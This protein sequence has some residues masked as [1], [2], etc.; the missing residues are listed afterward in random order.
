[1]PHRIICSLDVSRI[2][3][4]LVAILFGCLVSANIMAQ[5]QTAPRPLNA[6]VQSASVAVRTPPEMTQADVEAFLDGL[7]PAEIHRDD[8]AGVV[9][10]IVKDGKVLLEKGYGYADV[11]KRKPVSAT[12]TLFRP[13]STSKLFTW[14]AVMQLVEQGKLDLDRNVNDYL[15]FKIPDTFPQPITLRDIMTHRS[16]FEETVKDLF[17][18][19]AAHLTPLGTYVREHLP[20]RIFPPGSTPAYSNYATTLAGYI[21]ERVS[22]QPFNQ[23]ILEHILKPLGMNHSTPVQPLPPELQP[24]MSSGYILASSGAK[25]FEFVN[26]GPA[27]SMSV[28][29]DDMTHFMMAH[30]QDGRYG[31]AQILKPETVRLMH[32]AQFRPAPGMNAMALGF[33]EETRNGHRIIGHAGDTEY[34]HSDLHL[35]PDANVGFFISFN[36]MG[37]ADVSPRTVVF[38]KFLDRYFPYELPATRT[39]AQGASDVTAVSGSYM[40]SRRPGSNFLRALGM[41]GELHVY[42]NKD[43][44]I[45][46]GE[47][48]EVNGQPTHWEQILPLA[49]REVHG[50]DRLTFVHDHDGHLVLVTDFPFFVFQRVSWYQNKYFNYFLLFASLAVFALTVLLWPVGAVARRHYR[51]PLQ[52]TPRSSRLR[53]A[54]FTVSFINLAFSVG[55]IVLLTS[56]NNITL[57][58]DA[59]DPWL[60]LLQ[61]FGWLGVFGAIVVIYGV[62]RQWNER[63]WW[64]HRVHGVLMILACLSFSWFILYWRLLAFSLK[65]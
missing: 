33:Y 60:R 13:G 37:R 53:M 21:V 62:V 36:S 8:I 44:T 32:S 28:S 61:L 43:G 34:F 40:S 45:S 29:A 15:D 17:V 2:M 59:L 25:G 63:R 16:G 35:I 46:I 41:L 48:K 39:V 18:A 7:V 27:G 3:R 14:T 1:M 10:A 54:V 23:Y 6:P 42:G 20:R 50:Q 31:E 65:Y 11:A 55:L 30:L 52:L 38:K 49:Y 64:W 56:T 58:S 22:G 26:C 51:Q 57:F 24:L 12:E 47:M 9:I 5:Q 4:T 19:D